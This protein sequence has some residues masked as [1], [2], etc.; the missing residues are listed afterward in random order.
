MTHPSFIRVVRYYI[1]SFVRH[2]IAANS[3]VDRPSPSAGEQTFLPIRKEVPPEPIN[4]EEIPR[5]V[6]QTWKS[7]VDIPPNYRY[8]RDTFFKNN[9]E[10]QY[11]LWDDADNDEFI[12]DNFSWF[13]PTYK[14]LPAGIFR[15]DA[16]RPFFLFLYGGVYADMDTECLGPLLPRPFSGDVIL[17]QM[18]SN[19]SFVDSIPNAI[20]ASKPFQLFW[21][22]VVAIM[23]EKVERLGSDEEIRKAGPEFTTGPYLLHEAF[24]YYRSEPEQKVRAR[25]GTIIASLPK[26]VSA[27]IRAGRIE[28]LPADIWYPLDHQNPIYWRFRKF[29]LKD[30]MRLTPSEARLLFP[31]ASLLTYWTHSW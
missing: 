31:K 9:P 10:F 15:A 14:K 29:L 22:L 8:W 24:H 21:L 16:V 5:V 19:L 2:E 7:R 28:L 18:R 25:T 23:I 27:R 6:F 12:A 4:S 11:V 20:M 17:G 1:S 13:L 26:H 30:G 3:V